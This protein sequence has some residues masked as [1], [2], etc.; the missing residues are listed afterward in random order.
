[1]NY[2]HQ[3]HKCFDAV[4]HPHTP[5]VFNPNERQNEMMQIAVWSASFYTIKC[6]VLHH[7]LPQLILSVIRD[8]MIIYAKTNNHNIDLIRW[9]GLRTLSTQ[10]VSLYFLHEINQNNECYSCAT[11]YDLYFYSSRIGKELPYPN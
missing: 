1:M 2:T 5:H 6:H 10:Q 7:V 4:I 11:Q 9:S 3:H 8:E